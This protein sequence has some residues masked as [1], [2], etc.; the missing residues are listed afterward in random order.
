M[1]LRVIAHH[2]FF[3]K[4]ELLKSKSGG[5]R[6]AKRNKD[7]NHVFRDAVNDFH[8]HVFT[9]KFIKLYSLSYETYGTPCAD[10]DETR[11]LST[12]LS[13]D[14]LDRISP[15]TDTGL[16]IMNRNYFPRS[17]NVRLL[18]GKFARNS[19]LLNKSCENLCLILS[20]SQK[21][22]ENGGTKFGTHLRKVWC[23]LQQY[24]RNFHFLTGL[25]L[26][27]PASN[28][29]HIGQETKKLRVEINLRPQVKYACHWED[30]RGVNADSSSTCKEIHY[31][32][33]LI[34]EKRFSR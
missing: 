3:L 15:K 8:K 9:S 16:L 18:V 27:V 14:F 25:M 33:S 22:I 23:S 21:N 6:L 34:S 13:V 7:G 19:K 1:F 31:R 10:F 28:I 26:R 12:A 20:K 32:F 29:T 30:M 4:N 2:R 5:I 17:R 24:I 11:K